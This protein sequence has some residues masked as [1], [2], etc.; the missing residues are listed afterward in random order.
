MTAR[1]VLGKVLGQMGL[2]PSISRHR[3]VQ[4]WPKIVDAAVSRHTTAEKIVGSTL[5]VIVDSSVWM[6]E[7]SA[8]RSVLL[9]KVNSRI[10]YEAARITDIRFHQRS[11]ANRHTPKHDEPASSTDL[12]E[13]DVR[14]VRAL[15]EPV[16]DEELR[17]VLKRILEKDALLKHTH[18]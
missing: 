5:H 4:L 1:S 7:L 2:A 18:E 3:L 9:D 8:V 13:K 15:L 12:T 6:N 16:K 11:W 14:L 10:E 17:A